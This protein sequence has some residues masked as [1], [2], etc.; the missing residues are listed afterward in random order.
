MEERHQAAGARAGA[1]GSCLRPH[2]L[3]PLLKANAV[4]H[5]L[6]N[7]RTG[8]MVATHVVIA[9]DSASRRKGLLGRAEMPAGEALIIAPCSSVHTFFMKFTIDVAFVNRAGQVVRVCQHLAP[10]RIGVGFWAFA[11]VELQA[12]ALERTGTV[13]GDSLTLVPTPRNVG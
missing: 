13:R 12:G 11:A 7:T 9:V 1:R 2:F 6:Q 10:W 4:E 3:L 5:A 8:E